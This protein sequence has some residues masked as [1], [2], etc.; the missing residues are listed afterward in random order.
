MNTP[1]ST[2]VKIKDAFVP[3]KPNELDKE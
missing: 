1:Y 3:P 2:S